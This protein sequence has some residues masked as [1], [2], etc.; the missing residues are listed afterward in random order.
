MLKCPTKN[1]SDDHCSGRFL[2]DLCKQTV[3]NIKKAAI[4]ADEWLVC[5]DKP[6]GTSWEDLYAHLIDNYE[7]INPKEKVFTGFINFICHS[8]Y[9]DRRENMLNILS[10]NDADAVATTDATRAIARKSMKVT[11]DE[12]RST[13]TGDSSMFNSRGYTIESRMQIG[14]II[15]PEYDYENVH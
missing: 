10:K 13:N 9:N 15:S 7:R 1:L 2:L 4:I 5:N 3:A 8:K 12:L 6:S 11:K 14:K